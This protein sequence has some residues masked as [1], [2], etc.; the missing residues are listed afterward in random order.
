M[1]KPQGYDE[2][3]AV[4]EWEPL[5]LGGHV[6]VIKQAEAVMTSTGKQALKLYLDVAEGKQK[7]Y[8]KQAYAADTRAD[9]KWGCTYMQLIEGESTRYFKG[10][11][12]AIERSNEGYKFNW[13]E[14]TLAGK[15]I[16]GVFGREQ[17]AN[18][19]GEL[20][21]YTKCRFV[22]SVEAVRKGI[23][24]PED[25]LLNKQGSKVNYEQFSAVSDDELP[26]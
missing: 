2:V 11:I 5:E 23:P 7:E 16:G 12:E 25:K 8:F 13:D 26:F 17:Y 24:A 9:K 22:R 21:F 14:S 15:L 20:K 19:K 10:M 18:D 1:M 6:C 4:G 3:Q